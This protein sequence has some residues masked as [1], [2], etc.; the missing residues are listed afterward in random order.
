MMIEYSEE[1]YTQHIRDLI[2]ADL[3]ECNLAITDTGVRPLVANDVVV[4]P[5][6]FQISDAMIF[7]WG[8]AINYPESKTQAAHEVED[9]TTYITW[10]RHVDATI[11][12]QP[13]ITMMPDASSMHA[14]TRGV[15]ALT[16]A[17]NR[18]FLRGMMQ[19]GWWAWL[20]LPTIGP[21]QALQPRVPNADYLVAAR[22]FQLHVRVKEF[23]ETLPQV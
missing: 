6:S 1:T 3:A 7:I 17:L 12:V 22:L 16:H 8:G 9:G 11:Q 23:V 19:S 2:V 18:I 4:A 5:P 14:A 21:V 15:T 10:A 20:D 13:Q